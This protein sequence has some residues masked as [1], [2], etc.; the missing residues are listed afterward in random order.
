MKRPSLLSVWNDFKTFAF[1][2]NMIDLAVAVVIGAAFGVVIKSIVDNI[3][4]PLVSYVTPKMPYTDWHIGK[5]LIGKFLGDLLNFVI[6]AFA[7][8]IVVVKILG[9]V[10]KRMAD[11]K[12]S[13][14]V[15]KECPYCLSNIPA[16]AVKCSQCTADLPAAPTDVK[17]AA[18]L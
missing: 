9:A 8:F 15:M 16:K 3:I 5:V 6:V 1:K 18:S 11:S 12:P 17:P 4:M 10:V 2:G 13:E 7:I 14:P